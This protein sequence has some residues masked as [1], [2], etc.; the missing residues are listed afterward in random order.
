LQ[1][2]VLALQVFERAAVTVGLGLEVLGFR[3]QALD[4]ALKVLRL[5]VGD[6]SSDEERPQHTLD[7]VV[8]RAK[9]VHETDL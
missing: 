1:L 7:V 3:A 2:L 8:A 6:L 4:H 5:L 9:R